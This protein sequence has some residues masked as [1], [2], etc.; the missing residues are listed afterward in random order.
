[1]NKLK[2][3]VVT[4]RMPYGGCIVLHALYKYLDEL[5]EDVKLFYYGNISNK[6]QNKLAFYVGA[7]SYSLKCLIKN[8]VVKIFGDKIKR[9]FINIPKYNY[10][11][12]ILPKVDEKTVVIYPEIFYGNPLKAKRVVRWLLFHNKLYKQEDGK[13]I[14]YDKDDL[15]FCY[16]KVFNDEKLNPNNREL[17]LAYFDLD[18]YKRTN[19]G[20]RSGNCYILRKGAWRTDLPTEFDGPIIDNMTEEKKVET[21]NKCKYCISY[22]TQTAYSRIAALCGCISIVVPE[23][24]KTWRDYR[25]EEEYKSCKGI[26]FGFS[27]EEIQRAVATMGAVAEYLNEINQVGFNNVKKFV[28]EC[29]DYFSQQL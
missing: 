23:K 25:S 14:G 5:G 18:L 17:N 24:G 12:K 21:F 7:L 10:K 29:E 22:D 6:K 13:T 11:Q 2:Y 27:D 4:P 1:M 16:R 9:C 15:F 26:A 19:Y 8:N 20:E 28:E 3:I